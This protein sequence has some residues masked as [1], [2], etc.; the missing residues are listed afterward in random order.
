MITH[1]IKT[2]STYQVVTYGNGSGSTNLQ[3]HYST[4]NRYAPS[5]YVVKNQEELDKYLNERPWL[6]EG[7][8]VTHTSTESI[9]TIFTVHY[10]AEVQR[11]FNAL[12]EV[13]FPRPGGIHPRLARLVCCSFNDKGETT[14]QR[15]DDVADIR[16]LTKFEMERW[17]D[18]NLRNRIQAWKAANGYGATEATSSSEPTPSAY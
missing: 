16:P 17:I 13:R 15:W 5:E 14:W 2:S 11:S 12:H 9:K 7:S 6:T 4:R 10:I 1:E 18:D 3:Q 8:F